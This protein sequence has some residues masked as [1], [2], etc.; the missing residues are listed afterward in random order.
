MAVAELR[1]HAAGVTDGG[2][3]IDASCIRPTGSVQSHCLQN[4]AQGGGY[5]QELLQAR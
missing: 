5:A 2:A 1:R 4:A 3:E